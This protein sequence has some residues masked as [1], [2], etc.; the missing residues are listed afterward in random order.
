MG[1][2]AGRVSVPSRLTQP[3]EP[4]SLASPAQVKHTRWSV[5]QWGE[6][7]EPG[8]SVIRIGSGS[9]LM[10]R[11]GGTALVVAREEREGIRPV[12]KSVGFLL[13][14]NNTQVVFH[15]VTSSGSRP[16]R[17][18]LSGGVSRSHQGG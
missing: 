3:S 13:L 9:A 1:N 11:Y 2:R 16:N 4:S 7:L 6:S 14:R 8:L 10:R 15:L 18:Y 12:R 17:T 5:L